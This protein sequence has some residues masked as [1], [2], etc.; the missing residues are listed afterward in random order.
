M[1]L[2]TKIYQYQQLYSNLSYD[3]LLEVRS[4]LW[5][6]NLGVQGREKWMTIPDM[7]YHIA[8]RYSVILVSLSRNL[9]ITFFPL[10][11]APCITSSR[12]K[13]IAVGFVNNNHWVQ[14]KFKHNCPFLPNTNR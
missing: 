2:D 4:A 14:V 12:H 11:I 9:N 1:Q 5:V 6:A 10:V 3:T 7:G 13:M 8:S